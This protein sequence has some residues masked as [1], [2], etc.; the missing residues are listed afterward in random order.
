MNLRGT[1]TL[2]MPVR[3]DASGRS[4]MSRRFPFPIPRGWYQVACSDELPPGG[5]ER[6]RYFD[7][8]LIAGRTESGKAFVLDAHCPH[9]GA[10]LGEG[11]RIEGERIRCP[12]HGWCFDS[13]GIC[14]EVPYARKLP[15]GARLGR[16][17]M[18]ERNGMLMVWY[19]SEGEAPQWEVPH[20]SEFG[21]SG[22]SPYWRQRLTVETCNQEILEN[23]ADRAH[24]HFVHGTVDVPKTLLTMKGTTL[25]AEQ[26]TQFQ[27]P[28]GIVDG[29][30]VS[31]YEGLGF[32]TARFSG[33]CEAL[34]VL[35][36]TPISADRLDV[37]FSLTIDQ[38]R[39]ASTERGVGRAI[40]ENIIQQFV[41]DIPIWENKRY[42]PQ[43]VFCD[44]DGEIAGYRAWASQFY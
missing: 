7:R 29:G 38:S 37:R 41:E 6:L 13:E 4:V 24:F 10:D 44:G 12:F 30:I 25:R 9:L 35:A 20:L 26:I 33:I 2:L 32:G 18:V 28:Q 27:T 1:G 39:G 19:D 43:P 5:I 34:L 36:T 16:W 21:A 14:L 22:W 15:R 23:V 40:I 3:S 31:N 8:D 42:K 17:P 11:G